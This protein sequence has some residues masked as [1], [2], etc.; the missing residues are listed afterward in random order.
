MTSL[1]GIKRRSLMPQL[2][3]KL[4]FSAATAG[5]EIVAAIVLHVDL[6]LWMLQS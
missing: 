3:L 5:R 4:G 1:N 2:T 6:A